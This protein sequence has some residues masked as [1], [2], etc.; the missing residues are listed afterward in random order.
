MSLQENGNYE[1]WKQQFSI[2]LNEQQE[3]AVRTAEGS[4]LLLAVPGSGKTTVLVARLGYLIFCWG[5]L[6][7]NILTITYTVAAPRDMKRRFGETFG[8]AMNGVTLTTTIPVTGTAGERISTT[9]KAIAVKSGMQ[10]S[11]VTSA[12]YVIELPA[13]A[14]ST[15]A[16]TVNNGT[17]DGALD[18]LTGIYVDDNIAP[19]ALSP[20]HI[21]T[22]QITSSTFGI[23][24]IRVLVHNSM[25]DGICVK[26][27]LF[28][29]HRLRTGISND[30]TIEL[31]H[32]IIKV[33]ST[34]NFINGGFTEINN[35]QSRIIF[36]ILHQHV[37]K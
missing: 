7:E 35:F 20:S 32:T 11:S 30:T 24:I 31:A 17:C 25:K 13:P 16:V 26:Q 27:V 23:I 4:V 29:Y 6:P 18:K 8:E 36:L 33:I 9:I 22:I 2:K 37:S 34:H 15:Y 21:Q 3:R 19:Q 28:C 14:P 12:T 10:N 1:G 5:I